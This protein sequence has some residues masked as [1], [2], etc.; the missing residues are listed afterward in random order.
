MKDGGGGS[1]AK[2]AKVVAQAGMWGVQDSRAL[3]PDELGG[4]S[5][6]VC[7]GQG[8]VVF[9]ANYRVVFGKEGF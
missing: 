9:R 3:G 5:E 2:T 7:D 8:D 1:A 6:E 4:W